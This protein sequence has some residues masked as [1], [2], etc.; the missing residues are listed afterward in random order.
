MSGSY[1]IGS[2]TCMLAGM[3]GLISQTSLPFASPYE[4]MPAL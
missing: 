2:F 4:P 3:F 1:L